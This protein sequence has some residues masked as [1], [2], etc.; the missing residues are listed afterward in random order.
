MTDDR[1]NGQAVIW[2][3][4]AGKVHFNYLLINSEFIREFSFYN[5]ENNINLRPA[6]A[7]GERIHKK[8]S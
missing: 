6:A 5:R 1:Q 3:N 2:L 4:T 8:R 7:S